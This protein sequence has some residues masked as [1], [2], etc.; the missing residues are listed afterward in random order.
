MRR[1]LIAIVIGALAGTLVSAAQTRRRRPVRK[2]A[3]P[4][5]EKVRADVTCPSPLGVGVRT[6]LQ[7]C[8][9]LTGHDPAAGVLVSIP[10]HRGEATVSFDLHNRQTYSAEQVK[11]HKAYARYTSTVDVVTDDGTILDRGVVRS[12]FRTQADLVDWIGGGAG[13]GGV[14]AVAPTG[15]EPIVV[16]VPQKVTQLSILGE[17]LEVLRL[18]GAYTYQA[19]GLP[20]A[21]ISNVMVAYRP[22]PVRKRPLR[23]K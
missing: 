5:V 14:K 18:D 11:A 17:K 2:A 3:P 4:K 23:R 9:V 16:T 6:G 8:D 1:L 12:E 15:T 7:F 21:D 10:P 19:S 13:P 22:A 20:I